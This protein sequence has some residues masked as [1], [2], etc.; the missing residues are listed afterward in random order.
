MKDL[1]KW[2]E[3]VILSLPIA[4][5]VGASFIVQQ[6]WQQHALVLF[7]LLWYMTFI[8]FDVLGK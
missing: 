4:A 3:R 5:V 2:F 7:T 6:R 1:R 8:I